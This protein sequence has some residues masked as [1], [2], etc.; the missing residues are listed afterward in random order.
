MPGPTLRRVHLARQA[1]A[2][3]L[4][5]RAPKACGPALHGAPETVAKIRTG[6]QADLKPFEAQSMKVLFKTGR[7]QRLSAVPFRLA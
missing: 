4:P 5:Y 7:G 6:R 3:G 1:P 2:T